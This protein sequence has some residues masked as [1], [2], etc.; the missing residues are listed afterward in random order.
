MA[1][2]SKSLRA[3]AEAASDFLPRGNYP[4][5]SN[6]PKAVRVAEDLRA[7]M[8]EPDPIAEA[9]DLL[10]EALSDHV[11]YLTVGQTRFKRRVRK[12]LKRME[13]RK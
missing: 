7:A 5:L 10:E 4:E 3:A 11:G 1:E 8:S 12:F 13:G 2:T 9:C 6:R